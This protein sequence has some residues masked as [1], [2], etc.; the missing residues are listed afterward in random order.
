MWEERKGR[1]MIRGKCEWFLCSISYICDCFL[2]VTY[3]NNSEVI[4][5]LMHKYGYLPAYICK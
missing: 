5:I 1:G 4:H 2:L 3:F